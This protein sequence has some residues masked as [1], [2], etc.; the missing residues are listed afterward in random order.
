MTSPRK[1]INTMASV[2]QL[3]L[4]NQGLAPASTIEMMAS[5][6]FGVLCSLVARRAS[7][8]GDHERVETNGT[9]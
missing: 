2:F 3:S 4:L 1:T 5:G 9:G 7:V 6:Q 8:I